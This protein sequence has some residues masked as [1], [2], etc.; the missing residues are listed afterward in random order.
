MNFVGVSGRQCVPTF[1]TLSRTLGIH[2]KSGTEGQRC[3]NFHHRWYPPSARNKQR[4]I[5]SLAHTQAEPVHWSTVHVRE[6]M[7]DGVFMMGGMQY[8]IA[9]S[10]ESS[11][12]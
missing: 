6:Q 12:L 4:T 7:M 2:T 10:Q 1:S 9:K 11:S 5:V 3:L 8:R